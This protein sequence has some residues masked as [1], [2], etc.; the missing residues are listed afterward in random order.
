[1]KVRFGNGKTLPVSCYITGTYARSNEV[2]CFFNFDKINIYIKT[3]GYIYLVGVL[4]ITS[5]L[6]L[7]LLLLLDL[8]VGFWL[9]KLGFEYN[10]ELSWRSC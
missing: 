5:L 4:S 8:Q 9:G 6:Y 7:T 10:G 1:M 3:I 2:M